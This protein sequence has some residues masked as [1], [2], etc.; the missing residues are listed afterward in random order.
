M[1]LTKLL[2]ESYLRAVCETEILEQS[3]DPHKSTF[4]DDLSGIDLTIPGRFYKIF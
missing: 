4:D 2:N 1:S 3:I